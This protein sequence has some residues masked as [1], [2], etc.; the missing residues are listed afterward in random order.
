MTL[1]GWDSLESIK[2][3]ESGLQATTLA[4]WILLVAFEAAVH[5]WKKRERLFGAFALVAFALAVSG[6][7]VSYKYAGRRDVLYD[8]R[9]KGVRDEA[10]EEIKKA[11]SAAESAQQKATAA[12][13]QV[14]GKDKRIQQLKDDVAAT[15]RYTYVAGLTFNGMVYTKG[16]VTMPTEISQAVQGTWYEPSPDRFRP[17]CDTATLQSNR[18]AI[19]QFPD[20]PFTYYAIAY[21]MEKQ[22]VQEW[23]TYAE[24]A[25]ALFEQ[26]TTIGGHQRSHDD[27]LAYLRQLLSKSK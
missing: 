8:A 13:A 14:S 25:V 1:P 21:C 12:E 20:F 18:I 26:T 15:K 10:N 16:D 19:R 11:R 17:V 27:S 24:K 7:V 2:R 4:F 5:L 6:E 22:G 23:R 9:E 3:I